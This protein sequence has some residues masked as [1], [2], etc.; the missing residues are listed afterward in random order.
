MKFVRIVQIEY[1]QP[2]VD[3][4]PRSF[5]IDGVALT[6]RPRDPSETE[7]RRLV[8]A[9]EV[10]LDGRP[11]VD[12]DGKIVITEDVARQA[13]KAIELLADLLAVTTFSARKFL[14]RC[15]LPDSAV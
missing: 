9:A 14:L 10:L 1:S 8:V 13:E 5:E 2:I 15:Q 6:V 7:I 11:D 4:Q 3:S 12:R